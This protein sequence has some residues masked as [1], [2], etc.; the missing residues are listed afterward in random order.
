MTDII[1]E[2][3]SLVA[4]ATPGPWAYRPREFDDWGFIRVAQ[5][6][7]EGWQPIVALGRAGPVESDHDEHRRNK[8]DPYGP[9]AELIV[10]AI[11]HLP[12]LLDRLEAAEWRPIERKPEAPVNAVL[13]FPNMQF[14]DQ[15]GDP[16]IF[17]GLR[18]ILERYYLAFW[19]GEIWV[20]SGT[21]HDVFED[22]KSPD[23]LPTHWRPLPDAPAIRE[24]RP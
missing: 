7:A 5:A 17:G 9:N 24:V 6:D 4:K 14:H 2:L 15:H 8:T 13:W 19:D 3:R 11:N 20:E 23:D 18:D 22:W 12:A 1:Q 10:A 21:G 16:F